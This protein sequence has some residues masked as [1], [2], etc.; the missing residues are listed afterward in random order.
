MTALLFSPLSFGNLSLQNRIVRSATWEAMASEDGLVTDSLLTMIR[1]LSKGGCGL[2]LTGHSY[3]RRDGQASPWQTGAYGDVCR[4]GLAGMAS[5]AHAHNTPIALQL[6]HAGLFA[7]ASP[8]EL[9]RLGP[10]SVEGGN[11]MT[12]KDMAAIS[13]AFASAA[14]MAKDAGFDAVQI[15]LAHTYLLSQFLCPHTNTRTDEYGGSITNRARFPLEVFR[16][17]R[18]AVGKDYPVL[19]KINCSDFIPDGITPEDAVEVCS[20][21]EKAGVN[22]IEI[23]GGSNIGS[24]NSYPAGKISL[25]P[26]EG[27]YRDAAKLYKSKVKVPLILVGGFRSIAG[28]GSVLDQGIA[29]A[30]SFSRPFIRET[31]FPNKWAAGLADAVT[32]IS[33]NLCSKEARINGNLHCCAPR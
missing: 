11:A 14:G 7:A 2:I 25:G 24:R 26:E 15:H 1:N 6:S 13:G 20:M 31:D 16:A 28:A 4:P 29:D 32:C 22:G 3:V 30:V 5:V 21:M 19:L 23:S 12:G 27:Y 18:A 17:V 33:C 8:P 10:S 9:P